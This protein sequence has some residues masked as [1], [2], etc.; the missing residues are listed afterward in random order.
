MCDNECSMCVEWCRCT[1]LKRGVII[2]IQE[3]QA[4]N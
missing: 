2:C 4:Q 1:Y 3:E